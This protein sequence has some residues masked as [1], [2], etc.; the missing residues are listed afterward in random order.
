M[1]PLQSASFAHPELCY[2]QDG[3]GV[4][5]DLSGICGVSSKTPE[6]AKSEDRRDVVKKVAVKKVT[7]SSND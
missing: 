4:R 1:F 3:N 5:T 7:R 2:W 6:E